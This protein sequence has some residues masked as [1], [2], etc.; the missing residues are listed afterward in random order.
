LERRLRACGGPSG[1]ARLDLS[2][3]DLRATQLKNIVEPIR[4]YSLEVGRPAPVKSPSASTPPRLSIVVL[5]FANIGDDPEQEYFVDGVTESLTTD[6]SRLAG[7]FVIA[8]NTAFTY[9]GN[10]FD[11][12]QIGRDLNIRYVLEGGVQRSGNRMR[13]NVQLIDAETGAHVWAERF[14]KPVA[15]L[16]NMQDEIVARLAS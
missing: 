15:N 4:V 8:R 14:D 5:P 7:S 2:V 13:I 12:K 9:K 6:L 3:S 10:P 1:V 16:F 11:V